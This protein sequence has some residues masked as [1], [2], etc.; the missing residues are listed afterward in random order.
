MAITKYKY[1]A[2]GATGSG[3][4]LVDALAGLGERRR[5]IKS[6]LYVTNVTTGNIAVRVSPRVRVYKNQE[7][8]CDFSIA[9]FEM[10]TY[11]GTYWVEGI[12]PI[13]LDVDLDTGDGFQIGLFADG[14]T[15]SGNL[16][17]EYVD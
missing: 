6:V 14:S 16:Q 4:T 13:D 5:T 7:Q 1:I 12:K 15:P 10:D 8:I 3:E 11:S 17:I 2:V 9:S